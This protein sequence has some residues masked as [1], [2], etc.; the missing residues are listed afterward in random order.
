MSHRCT[1]HQ[2]ESGS[3]TTG[4][5]AN[6]V[7]MSDIKQNIFAVEVGFRP[8]LAQAYEADRHCHAC[9]SLAR[10]ITDPV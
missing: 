7:Q 9:S 1:M 8:F 10:S 5:T 3:P 4:S 2:P 6:S